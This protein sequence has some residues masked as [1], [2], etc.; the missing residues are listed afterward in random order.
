M[1]RRFGDVAF[2]AL[3]AIVVT[4]EAIPLIYLTWMLLG[5]LV[6]RSG[7]TRVGWVLLGALASAGLGLVTVTGYLLAYQ[8]VSERRATALTERRQAWVARWLDVLY[9]AGPLPDAPVGDD[10]VGALL[11]VRDTVRG[12]EA[13]R[14]T[15]LLTR[16]GVGVVLER[17]VRTGRVASRLEAL[18]ALARSRTSEVMPTLVAAIE[19]RE[20][21]IQVAAA[22]ATAR[23]LAAIADPSAREDAARTVVHALERAGLPFGV[24]EEMLILADDGAP[25]LVGGLL[26]REDA[27]TSFLRAALDAVA[28][29]KLLG[30]ATEVARFLVASDPEVRAAA[31]RAVSQT[32]LLPP[33]ARAAV[34]SA[35]VDEVEFVR[36][37]ATAAARL[38]PREQAL[39]VLWQ[40]LGDPSWWV[41]RA[42]AEALAAL[43]PVGLAELG[44]AADTHPDRYAR[45]M[46]AQALRDHVEQLVEAVA[47]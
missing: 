6:G 35:L 5:R 39:P 9:T 40:G 30:F 15:D 42:A 14:V 7:G 28:R 11:D 25:S 41:R 4:L 36:I 37:H 8:H 3:V 19:D 16:Y 23:T 31:L 46:A 24:L 17:R 1:W 32:G 43:G 27:P 21:A 20:P 2:A 18:D 13:D 29:L 22:R 44:R 10:A 34:R 12:V 47:G 26:D 45:D 38:L 33:G